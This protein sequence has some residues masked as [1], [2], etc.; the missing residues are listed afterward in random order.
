LAKVHHSAIVTRAVEA[1]LAS[2]LK[3]ATGKIATQLPQTK[4]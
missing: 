4:R 3:N 2:D 1:S